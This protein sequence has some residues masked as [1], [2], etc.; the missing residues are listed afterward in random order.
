MALLE[1]VDKNIEARAWQGEIPIQSRY[2]CGLA[3][4]KFFREIM[5]NGRFAG[6]HCAECEYT[7]VPPTIY[8]ERCFAKLDEWVEVGPEGTVQSFTVLLVAPDGTP[9]EEP[10]ILALI[11]L[12]GAD[13]VLVHRL[14]KVGLD[15]LAIGMRV[16]AVFK[17]K[18]EREGSI[19]DIVHFVPVN[20]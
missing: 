5:E 7:Y 8:C 13:S 4:E 20:A 12:D 17:P 16:K 18:K 11:Q 2:T 1:K 6:T 15:E 19:L 10:D 14:G 9:L 3:G